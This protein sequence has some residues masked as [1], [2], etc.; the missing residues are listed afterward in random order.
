MQQH[1]RPQPN[2][3]TGQRI[4]TC[5]NS[6]CCPAYPNFIADKWGSHTGVDSSEQKT[7][8]ERYRL[9]DDG[10]YLHAEITITDPVY[11]AEPVI[12]SHRWEKLADRE[13]IQAPC[14]MEAAQLYLEAGYGDTVR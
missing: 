1:G 7:L 6:R 10:L 13:V 2:G 8:V 5:F 3:F 9:S 11:L 12:F 14:T 4:A